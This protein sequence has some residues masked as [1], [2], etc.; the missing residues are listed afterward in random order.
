MERDTL[1]MRGDRP[2]CFT[3]LRSGEGIAEV[4]SF[5]LQQIPGESAFAH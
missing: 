1:K 3:N 5:L 2:W 4:E